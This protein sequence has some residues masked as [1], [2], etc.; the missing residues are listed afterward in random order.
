DTDFTGLRTHVQGGQ[1]SRG[2]ADNYEFSVSFGTEIGERG[3]LLISGERFD[4]DGVHDYSD[5]GWYQGWGTVPDANGMLQIRPRVVSRN[6]S[7]DGLI[8]A[9]GSS[10]N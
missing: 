3:H 1:T 7:F 5:R 9:P 10:L 8:F 6:S 2:D 4:Q